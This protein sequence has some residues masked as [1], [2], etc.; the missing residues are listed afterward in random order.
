[1][2]IKIASSFFFLLL[3][4][5]VPG[6]GQPGFTIP[7][8]RIVFA[9]DDPGLWDKWRN[10]L[11]QLRTAKQKELHYSDSLYTREAFRWASHCYS[12]CMLMLFDQRF[13]NYETGEYDV[14]GFVAEGIKQFGGYDGVV[15]WHAYPRIGFDERNQFDYYREIKELKNLVNQFHQKGIRVFIDYNPWDISTRR[16]GKSDT[17]L[18]AALIKE[19]DA[20]GIFL[21]T[22]NGTGKELRKKL[23][24]VREGIVLES[25][26]ELSVARIGDH[27]MSW[28]QWY[29]D[30]YTPGVLWNKWFERRHMLHLIR[31]WDADHSSELHTAWMNGCGIIVWDNIFGTANQWNERDKSILRQI[32]PVQ[33]RYQTIFSGE[34]WKPLE[35]TA[36]QDVFANEWYNDSFRIWTLVNRSNEDRNGL[37][38]R[39]KSGP[40]I[41][42]FNLLTGKEAGT[43]QHDSVSVEIGI[44]PR[45][46]GAIIAI[47]EKNIN[48]DFIGF[49]QQQAGTDSGYNGLSRKPQAIEQLIPYPIVKYTAANIPAGMRH[50]QRS[51]RTATIEYTEREC[52]FFAIRN[53]TQPPQVNDERVSQKA[54][55]SLAAYA[56]DPKP[57]S[58]AAFYTFLKATH[59]RPADP[60]NFL[61]HW[62]NSQPPKGREQDAVVYINLNDARAYAKWAG[63]R[64]PTD[65][66]WQ[67]AAEK[68]ALYIWGNS[69]EW[70]E[71]E[72]TD[73][74]TRFCILKGGSRYK[75]KG[76]VWYADGGAQK[77]NFSA[78][79]I[80]ISPGLDRCSTIG[81]RCAADL[82]E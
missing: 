36:L 42:Y 71:T 76:S 52:G 25:E 27:H 30:S 28:A 12:V 80:M 14:N 17:D 46:V 72:R 63:K 70:T 73:G 48:A 78:K 79:F 44:R 59:Y 81:F 38:F 65:H 5:V 82:E 23:D 56:I 11:S 16:E 77:E 60:K 41:K 3:I 64:L 50:I 67:Y 39:I 20:D 57:V 37:L 21:D 4:K 47:G 19:I 9:P 53:K 31:R 40:G 43:I 55:V 75:A 69:W 24:S 74:L 7:P 32:V 33:R 18:L 8:A 15:L 62:I 49:L 6:M 51:E 22:M 1:M 45:S 68:H 35:K 29:D 66:E 2:N 54:I 61:K 13:Y 34:G 58:N 10:T 26:L